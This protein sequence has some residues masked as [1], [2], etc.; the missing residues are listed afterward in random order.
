MSDDFDREEQAFA[1]AL[2]ASVESE[3]FRP[4]DPGTVRPAAGPRRRLGGP[5]LKGLAAA[6]AVVVVIGGG[7]FVL[8][9]FGGHAV[10]A[11]AGS[12]PVAGAAAP[13]DAQD[14]ATEAPDATAAASGRF[15]SMAAKWTSTAS[16]P[17]SPRMD[18][19]VGWL[20]GRFY[21]ASGYDQA[22]CGKGALC[23]ASSALRDGASYDPASNTWQRIADAPAGLAGTSPVAVGEQLYFL[24][25]GEGTFVSYDPASDSW[26]TL[27]S[28]D[29]D[30][31]LVAAGEKLVEVAANRRDA[32]AEIDRVYDPASGAWSSLPA[33]PLGTAGVREAAWADGLLVLSATQS[34]G[35]SPTRLAQ[36]DLDTLT[37]TKLPTRTLAGHMT[38]VGS[39]VVWPGTDSKG[40]IYDLASSSWTDVPALAKREVQGDLLQ[41][42][43]VAGRV[44]V[45]QWLLDPV[46][47]TWTQL[48]DSRLT[49]SAG[50][51]AAGSPDGLL[52]F[53]GWTGKAFT[54]QTFFLPVT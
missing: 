39:L 20:D 14:R 34:P 26:S 46:E 6:A 53:G 16:S 51:A 44:G 24:V 38:A 43:V 2:R 23:P 41:A 27:P 32:G 3:E 49:A 45:G 19:A 48:P 1:E 11:S 17:L 28:G 29:S 12:A 42:V 52:L 18:A 30:G 4:L 13:E 31:H 10:S 33:D 22:S 35:A 7:G 54:A 40:A 21:V 9:R 50:V 15:G 37:W 25:P 8:S 5:W 36:L 47:L